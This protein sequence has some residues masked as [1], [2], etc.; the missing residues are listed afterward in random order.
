[1]FLPV[2]S[3][4]IGIHPDVRQFNQM[5]GLEPVP[6][7]RHGHEL[8]DHEIAKQLAAGFIVEDGGAGFCSLWSCGLPGGA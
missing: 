6:R 8:A 1:M 3:R 7:S 5:T 2:T 4:A